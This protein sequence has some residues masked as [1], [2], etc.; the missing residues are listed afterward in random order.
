MAENTENR[1]IPGQGRTLAEIEHDRVHQEEL[2]TA[3]DFA[4]DR[5]QEALGL[6]SKTGQGAVPTAE[7]V[8]TADEM[9]AKARPDEDP[10]VAKLIKTLEETPEKDRSKLLSSWMSSTDLHPYQVSRA[11]EETAKLDKAV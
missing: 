3:A 1:E 9:L 5:E 11:L 4:R 2:H 8:P 10:V 6:G 7:R